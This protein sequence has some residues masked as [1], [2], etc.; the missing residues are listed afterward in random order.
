LLA[1]YFLF[2]ADRD[3]TPDRRDPDAEYEI[4]SKQLDLQ[5]SERGVLGSLSR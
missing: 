3:D 2:A 5:T 4:S 1:P